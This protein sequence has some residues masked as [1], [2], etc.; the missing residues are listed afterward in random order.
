M[1]GNG[2]VTGM[3][4]SRSVQVRISGNVQGCAYRDW[5]E[6][7]AHLLGLAGW[8]RNRKDG[9]VEAM[10]AGP[11]TSVSEMISRCKDGPQSAEVETV[12]IL[13][14]GCGRFSDE[15]DILPTA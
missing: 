8:V 4:S 2:T 10:F 6:K 3:I 14:E 13:K 1:K 5:T 11:D 15:F 12:D 9:S 7:N